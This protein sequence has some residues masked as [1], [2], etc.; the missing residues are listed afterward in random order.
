MG[1][2]GIVSKRVGSAY[3]SGN[4]QNWTRGEEIP[5]RLTCWVAN[6][7]AFGGK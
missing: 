7:G 6:S 4:Y 5:H 2:E 1:L 3:W